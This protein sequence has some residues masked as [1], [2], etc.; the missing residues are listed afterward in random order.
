M[1]K[2]YLKS[3]DYSL[4]IAITLLCTIGAVMV[5]SASSIVAVMRYKSA[6]LPSDYFFQ[7]QVNAMI[8]GAFMFLLFSMLPYQIFRKRLFFIAN[9]VISIG[10]LLLVMLMGEEAN[11][12]K[13][14]LRIGGFK[15]QPAEFIKIGVIIFLA[16][17]YGRN[18]T[19]INRFWKGIVPPFMYVLVIFVLINMQPDLGT[20]LLILGT[21]CAMVFASGID[22]KKIVTIALMVG[23]PVGTFLYFAYD[24]ILSPHQLNRF[25]V[26]S[27]P[28]DY[29]QDTGYQLVHGFISITRGGFFG[30]GLGESTQK[31][32]HLPEPHTDFIMAII[33]E[34]LGFIG[35]SVILLGLAFVV[36]R[37]LMIARKCPDAF[38]SLL[39]IG[40]S[41]MVAIQTTVNI[42]GLTGL[43]PLTGVPL[44]FISY[45]GTSIVLLFISMGILMNIHRFSKARLAKKVNKN[46]PL[47]VVK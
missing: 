42:G 10:L 4:I 36:F 37:G 16:A 47:E 43:M 17:L 15:F 19:I 38:G 22:L 3:L 7:E 32:G 46:S 41:S 12:A 14:W 9:I 21:A 6:N 13:S 2:R 27:N 20:S 39:A 40:I 23:I 26:T 33:A 28:F 29:A 24:K 35:V 25:K 30:V 44:P 8:L 45:G 11:G 5:Y 18:Q 1:I 31:Y 34:E